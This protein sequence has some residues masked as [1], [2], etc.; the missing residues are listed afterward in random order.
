MIAGCRSG[1]GG[2]KPGPRS[3]KKYPAIH[4]VVV[5]DGN[6]SAGGFDDVFLG[7]DAAEDF[8]HGLGQ[9]FRLRR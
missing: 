6:A 1:G 3:P 9:L 7:V 5:E 2:S 4:R 8:L